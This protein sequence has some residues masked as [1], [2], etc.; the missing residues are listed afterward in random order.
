MTTDTSEYGLESLI[1]PALAG[2]ACAPPAAGETRKPVAGSGGIGWS[3]SSYRDYDREFCV[4]LAQLTVFHCTTQPEAAEALALDD[5]GPTRRKFLARLQSEVTKRGI[6][7]VLRHG[8][9]HGAHDHDLFYS[10]PEALPRGVP[11]RAAKGP[12][13]VFPARTEVP[14]RPSART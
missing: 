7:D 5:N 6:I 8:I 14:G 2:E 10:T 4:D 9:R 1:C 3:C 13:R 12:S 11:R